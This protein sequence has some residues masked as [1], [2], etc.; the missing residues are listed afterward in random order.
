MTQITHPLH[1]AKR[2]RLLAGALELLHCESADSAVIL[3]PGSEPPRYVAIGTAATIGKLLE[4]DE[5]AATDVATPDPVYQVWQFGVGGW[6]DATKQEYDNMHPGHRQI[7]SRLDAVAPA[8]YLTDAQIVAG[9]AIK[10]DHGQAIGRNV[11]IDVFD[12]MKR[13]GGAE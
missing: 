12:A 9:A 1:S 5:P 7:A 10:C 4:I 3:I 13:E 6:R 11:A 2:L 8:G